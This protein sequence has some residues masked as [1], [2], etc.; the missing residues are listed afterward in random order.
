MKIKWTTRIPTKVGQYLSKHFGVNTLNLIY[1]TA[2]DLEI[3]KE[4]ST[5]L[6]GRY[7]S[8]IID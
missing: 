2:K 3:Q 6:N 1:I 7:Y 4:N 5:H 8:E